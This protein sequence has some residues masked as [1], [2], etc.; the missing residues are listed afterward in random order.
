MPQSKLTLCEREIIAF[1]HHSGDCV[2]E[3]ARR[4]GR[5]RT[6]ISRELRRNRDL[7]GDY[8][9]V[10]AHQ[11]AF[12]RRSAI[13]GGHSKIAENEALQSV[14]HACLR[15]EYWSPDIL[16]GCLRRAHRN[17]KSMRVCTQT[18]YS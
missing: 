18:I 6:T 9:P 12:E 5:H 16:A 7:S 15:D 11:Q 13:R 3:I 14:V 17:D 2:P 4:I 8:L 1:R 10:V